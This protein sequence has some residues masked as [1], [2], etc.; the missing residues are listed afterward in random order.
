MEVLPPGVEHRDGADLGAQMLGIGSNQTQGVGSRL[1]QQPVDKL[2]VVEGDV[3][4]GSRQG[5]DQVE[6][7]PAPAKAGGTGSNS[8]W[9]SAS[10]WAA[11]DP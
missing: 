8:A 7:E 3:A 10:H 4:K 9:R 5:E 1:E 2:L 11:A 6:V